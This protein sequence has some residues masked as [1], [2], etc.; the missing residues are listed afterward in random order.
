MNIC[1][2]HLYQSV[3]FAV[4]EVVLK[5]GEVQ[6]KY[7]IHFLLMVSRYFEKKSYYLSSHERR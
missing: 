3:F 2:F 6:C 7:L 5:L 4:D 1:I